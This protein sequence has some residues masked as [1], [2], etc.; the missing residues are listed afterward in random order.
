MHIAGQGLHLGE[1]G[2][3]MGSSVKDADIET[4]LEQTGNDG[5][6]SGTRATNHQDR[7]NHACAPPR[8]RCQKLIY[9]KSLMVCKHAPGLAAGCRGGLPQCYWYPSALVP[10]R[11]SSS[12]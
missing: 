2:G 9:T 11:T 1:I 4:S 12:C 7:I 3:L 5:W 8:L 10:Q 6:P